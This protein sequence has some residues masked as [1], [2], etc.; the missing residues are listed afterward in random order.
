MSEKQDRA[1]DPET[2]PGDNLDYALRPKRLA[3][4]IGQTQI[5]ENIQILIE[6]SIQ[7]AEA[8]DHVIFYGPPG[9]GKTT[10]AHVIAN[11]R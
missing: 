9:L 2:K 3:D 7:R 5:K 11:E 6:A 10:L 4:L 1:I 8:L